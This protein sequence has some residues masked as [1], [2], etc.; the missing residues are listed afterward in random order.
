MKIGI[1]G[2]GQI[3]A[4]LARRL[5]AVGH[6]VSIANL[7]GP[8]SLTHL[9]REIGGAGGFVLPAGQ[10]GATLGR[11]LTG[12]GH[13]VWIANSRGPAPP[14]ALA[15][16]IGGR[17]VPVEQAARAGDVVV[18]PI[19]MKNIPALPAGLFEGVPDNVV[20]VDT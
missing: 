6:D 17:A 8:A 3:G 1:I 18:V 7:R 2:A 10:L 16:E 14:P 15:R 13:D 12:V 4:T 5:T 20:V 9:A 19:P 11:R